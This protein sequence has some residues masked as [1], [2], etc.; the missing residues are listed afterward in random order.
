[1]FIKFNETFLRN[2]G[3]NKTWKQ[4][5]RS[6]HHGHVFHLP[7]SV[8]EV[9]KSNCDVAIRRIILPL[10]TLCHCWWHFGVVATIIINVYQNLT[11]FQN[12]RQSTVKDWYGRIHGSR[13]GTLKLSDLPA[14]SSFF[15]KRR[16]ILDVQNL[17][18]YWSVNWGWF[19]DSL[20]HLCVPGTVVAFLSLTQEMVGS[21]AIFY[22]NRFYII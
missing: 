21:N 4:A 8:S 9:K 13:A 16:C 11:G 3:K 18:N 12:L 22:K 20:Y 15:P 5:K 2:D 14:T 19:N 17:I 10:R 1:M 7:M 6:R